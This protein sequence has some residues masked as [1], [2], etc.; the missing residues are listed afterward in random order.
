VRPDPQKSLEKLHASLR[1]YRLDTALAAIGRYNVHLR[2]P[3]FE[4]KLDRRI[5][6]CWPQ[7]V[8]AHQLVY[9]AKEL[10][11]RSNDYRREDCKR[12]RSLSNR[13]VGE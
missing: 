7:L 1:R 13:R 12:S 4:A 9:I 6:A 3:D 8:N 2:N 11:K 5:R 10:I